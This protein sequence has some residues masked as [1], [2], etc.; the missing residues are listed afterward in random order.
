ME[1]ESFILASQ[2]QKLLQKEF[3]EALNGCGPEE[4]VNKPKTLS[5][6]EKLKRRSLPEVRATSLSVQKELCTRSEAFIS[7]GLDRLTSVEFAV[8]SLLTQNALEKSGAIF[9]DKSYNFC[10]DSLRLSNEEQ[11]AIEKVALEGYM[12]LLQCRPFSYSSN[13]TEEFLNSMKLIP[14][15]A[16]VDLILTREGPKVIEANFQWVD[17]I[18]ALE[19]LKYT[20]RGGSRLSPTELFTGLFPNRERLGIVF[21]NPAS[22][23]STSGETRSL[24]IMARNLKAKNSFSE[25]EILDPAKIR[26]EYLASFRSLYIDGDPRMVSGSE[27]PDWLKIIYSQVKSGSITIFPTWNPGFDK[28][29]ILIEASDRWPNLFAPTFAF[30]ENNM[31]MVL[32]DTQEWVIK[33]D[34]FSGN[35]VAISQTQLFASIW[36]DALMFPQEYVLQPKLTSM[37][38]PPIWVFETSSNRPF[39][40]KNPKCKFNVWIIGGKIAGTTASLSQED[41]ISDKDFNTVPITC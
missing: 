30:A 5:K 22:G 18:Q 32:E 10:V 23:S 31:L 14:N 21:L 28:K 12:K 41:I 36:Q 24:E 13:R 1:F 34:G 26:P 20:F 9:G 27:V 38:I 35:T 11:E 4:K 39:L 7:Q 19:A 2:A 29:P 25:I 33:G 16:R 15:G 8:K 17:G 6:A 3:L 37:P 40:L